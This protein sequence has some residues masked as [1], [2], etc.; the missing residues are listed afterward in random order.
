[1][2]VA[3]YVRVSFWMG[4]HGVVRSEPVAEPGRYMDVAECAS[5]LGR[6]VKAVYCLVAE[7]KIPYAKVGRRVQFDRVKLDGWMGRHARRGQMV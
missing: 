1:M 6:S 7:G 5:Y 4:R 3:D 2:T